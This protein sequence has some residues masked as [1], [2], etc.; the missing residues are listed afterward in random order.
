MFQLNITLVQQVNLTNDQIDKPE[1]LCEYA[2]N[3]TAKIKDEYQD[4]IY[5]EVH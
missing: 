4:L 3:Q 5:H 2:D 1:Y